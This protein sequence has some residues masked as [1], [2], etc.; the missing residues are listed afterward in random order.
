MPLP[1]TPSAICC[2]RHGFFSGA[3]ERSGKPV[4]RHGFCVSLCRSPV[5]CPRNRLTLWSR[6]RPARAHLRTTVPRLWQRFHLIVSLLCAIA[7]ARKRHGCVLDAA[8]GGLGRAR[9]FSQEAEISLYLKCSALSQTR[10]ACC[11]GHSHEG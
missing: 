7:G 11:G 3:T 5:A 9:K 1:R 4:L 8:G 10:Q 2:R 6:A